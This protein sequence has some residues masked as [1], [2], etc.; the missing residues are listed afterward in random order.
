M[1]EANHQQETLFDAARKLTDPAQRKAFLDAACGGDLELRR[2][3][4]VLLAAGTEADKFF[5]DGS[6][7]LGAAS[8]P[9][10]SP[11][12]GGNDGGTVRVTLPP[13]ELPGTRI[14]HYKLREKIGEGG[15][16]L[17]YVAEQEEPVRRRVALKVIKPGMDTRQVIARFEAERQALAMMDHPNIAK[18]LDAGT[19]GNG[20]PFFV[21]ELVRGIRIT[22]YCDQN[23][24]DT[25]RRLE[26]F[27]QVCNAVQHAHQKGIIH[28]DLKPSNILVTLH[29]GV[30]VPKVIDFG[31]AKATEGRLT[32]LTVYTALHQF[33]GT[34]AYMSPEQAEMTG[35]D[36]D[37]RSDIYSLGVL[38]YELLTGNTPFD[39]K[40]LL[41]KGL[42]EI[43]RTIREV[44]PPRPSTRLDTMPDAE[45]TTV[46]TDRS[47][48]A[49]RL[50]SQLRGDL[51]WVVMKC[52]EKDR[53]RRYDTAS[54]LSTDLKRFLHNEPVVA[55]PPSTAYRLT[56]LARRNKLALTAGTIVVLALVA[57]L[58]ISTRALLREQSARRLAEDRRQ[59]AE[60]ARGEERQQRL[61]AEAGELSARQFAYASDMNLI[62]QALGANNL[63]RAR[64]VLQRNVP[65]QDQVDLRCWEWRHYW[66]RCKSDSLF[67]LTQLPHSVM[68][69]S[70]AND[71]DFVVFRDIGGV[72]RLWDLTS[73]RELVELPAS[74]YGRALAVT[75]AG[76]LAYGD[77]ST[78]GRPAISIW[79]AV[80]RSALGRVETASPAL[81][82]A[83]ASNGKSVA[84]FCEDRSVKVWDLESGKVTA[85]FPARPPNGMHKGVVA[86]SPDASILAFGETDG[87]I[88]LFDMSTYAEKHSLNA[89]SDGITAL[90]FSP[91][92]NLL[93]SGSG[94]SGMETVKLWDVTTGELTNSFSGHNS[95]VTALAFAPD[96]QTIA[97]ASGDQTIRLWDVAGRK[98]PSLLRGHLDE[99]YSVAF[100]PNGKTLLSGSKDGEVMLWDTTVNRSE[101]AYATLPV[102]VSKFAFAPR[103]KD[104]VTLNR[105]GKIVVWDPAAARQKEIIAAVARDG[106][107]AISPSGELLVVGDQTGAVRIWRL[108][109]R[110][111]VTNF[112]VSAGRPLYV[113][114]LSLGKEL[115]TVDSQRTVRRRETDAW[116]ETA[117]WAMERSANTACVSPDGAVLASGHSDGSVTIWDAA[118]GK[119]LASSARHRRLVTGVAFSP[120]GKLMATVGEDGLTKLWDPSPLRELQT[121]RGNLL[122]VHSVSFSDDGKRLSVGG[123]T[124]EA[125]K[126]WDVA[127]RQEVATL[128][129]RGSFF[130]RT[131]FSP[132]A[133]IVVSVNIDGLFHLWHA[134][135][136]AEIEATEQA[137]R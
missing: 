8:E 56:K 113:A 31:I 24:L 14:G 50:R 107:M 34:P 28:R 108:S 115:L 39:A 40:E 101:D 42:D 90:A 91:T 32:D 23:H 137:R 116:R 16:G 69:S 66:R 102:P 27:V 52:L 106:E 44:E 63:G 130:Y 26:L 47:T 36:I 25:A 4:E 13:E 125:I 86:F 3:V 21:M 20:R 80:T 1:N 73:R 94:F 99:V 93:A 82:L 59:D 11:A 46:A 68:A 114:F 64:E 126:V 128:A 30:A 72:I 136:L 87:R 12:Q 134:P 5:A 79:N 70:F 38:L 83:L 7:A 88:R 105:D 112:A 9:V 2:R 74:G 120:D 131:A 98:Q 45:R 58:G 133:N 10:E 135:S 85:T 104:L 122:A 35:L 132:D 55:R 61:R 15:C 37:T 49:M 76:L 18:V 48:D 29:D 89:S 77:T 67:T 118:S 95:W 111:A 62:Q 54:G 84:A 17:V 100:S 123:H 41:N 75:S 92:G 119:Q 43:R 129:G 78:N 124:K 121:L 51:D 33:I 81:A 19:T 71:G 57:G 53:N 103:G 60:T 117:S 22:D 65:G 6:A 127:T 97:S 109:D 96:G 110:S